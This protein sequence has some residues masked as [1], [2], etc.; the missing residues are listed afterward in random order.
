MVGEAG[1]STGGADGT[2]L[3]APVRPPAVTVPKG[4]GAIRGIAEKFAHPV[5]GTRSLTVPIAVGLGRSG[6]GPQLALSYASRA[7]KRRV[8]VRPEPVAPSNHPPDRQG[9]TFW[10][11]GSRRRSRMSRLRTGY[12]SRTI[13]RA[14]LPAFVLLLLAACGGT[15]ST[16]SASPAETSQ[17]STAPPE[18]PSLPVTYLEPPSMPTTVVLAPLAPEL[19]GTWRTSKWLDSSG[20]QQFWRIYQ[21]TP[22]GLYDYTLAMCR[23]ST[24]CSLEGHESG[25]ARAANGILKLEPQTESEE[26]PRAWPYVVGR[27]PDV[28]DIQLH[29]TLTDGQVDIFYRD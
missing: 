28:G 9:V 19:V 18:P 13:R 23:S 5:T 8:R 26:G 27:D 22:D 12:A 10:R 17:P 6:F 21:F 11:T 20:S 15:P 2:E 25:Y 16:P 1:A 29:L 24:D 7:G 14:G 4:G 3:G